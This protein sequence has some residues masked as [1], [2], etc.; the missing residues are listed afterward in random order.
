MLRL[1]LQRVSGWPDGQHRLR[2]EAAADFGKS[3]VESQ[4]AGENLEGNLVRAV[5]DLLQVLDCV[6]RVVECIHQGLEAG[7]ESVRGFFDAVLDKGAALLP[8]HDEVD[9]RSH[10]VEDWLANSRWLPCDM[11][12][13]CV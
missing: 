12:I 4:T 7:K 2:R 1:Q 13:F 8:F 9:N 10:T 6:C 3:K 5:D 11:L